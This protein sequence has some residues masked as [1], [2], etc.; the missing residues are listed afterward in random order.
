MSS[1][2]MSNHYQTLIEKAYKAFNERDIETVISLMHSDVKWP[3][4][5]EGGYVSGTEEVKDYWRRQWKELDPT[6][7]PLSVNEAKDG[8]VKV[9]VHQVVKDL[10]GKL[11]TDSVVKH[12]YTFEN[13][14][15]KKMEVSEPD[16]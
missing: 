15:I 6:V 12:T 10:Q 11:L 8:L 7:I 1:S 3:N 9:K 16:V 2:A 13:G 4:A 5:W 14:L